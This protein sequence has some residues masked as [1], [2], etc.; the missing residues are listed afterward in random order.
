MRELVGEMFFTYLLV[1]LSIIVPAYADTFRPHGTDIYQL[2]TGED[3]DEVRKHWDAIFSTEAYV[4]GK[5]P[6]VF[7]KAH[8]HALPVGKVLD[9]A[10]GEGRNAVFMAKKGFLVDGVDIS[11]IALKKANLLARENNVSINTVN[12]DLNTYEIKTASYDVILNINY[13]QRSLVPQIKKGL[14]KGGMIVFENYTEDQLGNP[15]GR[16]IPREY[17]L[18]KGELLEAFKDFEVLVY[19][20]NNDGREAVAT[21]LAKKR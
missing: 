10:T 8:V 6:S 3:K 21:L 12:A 17:L 20:E 15:S 16:G 1:S 18:R 4:F 19:Q 14:K 9:I 7:L 13:L 11:E 5:D 2:I